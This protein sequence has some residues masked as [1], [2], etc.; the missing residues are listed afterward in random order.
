M[1]ILTKGLKIKMF[2]LSQYFSLFTSQKDQGELL[3]SK[4]CTEG[5]SFSFTPYPAPEKVME[6]FKNY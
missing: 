2:G 5:L 4:K 3:K 6:I 1:G